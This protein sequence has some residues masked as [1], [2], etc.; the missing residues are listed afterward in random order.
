LY[1]IVWN[2]EIVDEF[3]TE[4]EADLMQREY[5]LAFNDMNIYVVYTEEDK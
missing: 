5:C 2:G 3:E 1:Q 4:E